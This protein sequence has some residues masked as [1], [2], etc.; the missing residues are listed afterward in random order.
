MEKRLLTRR[1]AAAYCSVSP[2]TFD[3]YV[4]QGKLPAKVTGMEVWDRKAIDQMLDLA[5]GLIAAVAPADNSNSAYR[6]WKNGKKA[7]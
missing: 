7:A 2:T 5:S 1:E 3:R 4:R 6:N